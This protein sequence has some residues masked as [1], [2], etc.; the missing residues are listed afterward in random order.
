MDSRRGGT[1]YGCTAA[2]C[3]TDAGGLWAGET[4]AARVAI[5]LLS[6]S[7]CQT[8]SCAVPPGMVRWGLACACVGVR[9]GIT[10]ARVCTTGGWPSGGQP[11]GRLKRNEV[12]AC[13]GGR[14]YRRREWGS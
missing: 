3:C 14:G 1:W 11:V 2:I 7:G 4:G 12:A 8:S 10:Q 6:G 5:R 9:V 13:G